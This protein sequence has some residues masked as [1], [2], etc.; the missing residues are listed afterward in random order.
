MVSR[1]LLWAHFRHQPAPD[2]G[3]KPRQGASL[4][5]VAVSQVKSKPSELEPSSTAD[6]DRC[7]GR[8]QG[9]GFLIYKMDHMSLALGT[10]ETRTRWGA[11]AGFS[12]LVQGALG[13]P[14]EGLH[15]PAPAGQRVCKWLLELPSRTTHCRAWSEAEFIYRLLSGQ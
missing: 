10:G 5:L 4:G 2:L 6:M 9:E 3:E 11:V 1:W 12:V 8:A 15:E 14:R 13:L 7:R